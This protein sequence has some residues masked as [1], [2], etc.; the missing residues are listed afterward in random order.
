MGMPQVQHHYVSSSNQLHALVAWRCHSRSPFLVHALW[1]STCFLQ[2]VSNFAQVSGK[3]RPERP[4]QL[5]I[6][7]KN[8]YRHIL[9][10]VYFF[11][12]DLC[13]AD[14]VG[15]TG[16]HLHQRV[17]EHVREQHGNEPREIA[18]NFSVLSKCSNKFDCLIFQMFFILDL[19]PKFNKQSDSIRAKLFV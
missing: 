16:R 3:V 7:V 19:K 15:Y 11:K 6:E 18:K 10:I 1:D 12:C 5:C 13:D 2:S 14:Y 8:K 9:H 17:E 4:V